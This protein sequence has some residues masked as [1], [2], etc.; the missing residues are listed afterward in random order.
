MGM[1]ITA[2]SAAASEP[3]PF[4]WKALKWTLRRCLQRRTIFP[5]R[6]LL[7]LIELLSCFYCSRQALVGN[8]ERTAAFTQSIFHVLA[9]IVHVGFPHPLLLFRRQWF[10]RPH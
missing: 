1:P 5:N 8:A 7:I 10:Q 4:C 9:D 3:R 2:N 6:R